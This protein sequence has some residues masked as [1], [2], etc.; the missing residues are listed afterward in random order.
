M[1]TL[2]LREVSSKVGRR[3]ETYRRG[4]GISYEDLGIAPVFGR[5]GETV[6]FLSVYLDESYSKDSPNLIVGGFVSGIDRWA[7]F[8]SRWKVEVQEQFKVP[9]LHMK[10]LMSEKSSLYRHLHPN[11]WVGLLRTA[12]TIIKEQADFAVAYSIN[13]KEYEKITTQDERSVYG[14]AY[15]L[16]VMGCLQTIE[17]Q[18][19]EKARTT[20]LNIYLENGHRSMDQAI[21]ILQER[22]R[23]QRD[24]HLPEIPPETI[25]LRDLERK[26]EG[27][28]VQLGTIA[29]G[30]KSQMMPLQAADLLA[31]SLLRSSDSLF[32]PLLFALVMDIDM[33]ISLLGCHMAAEG[34]RVSLDK[35]LK[36][37]E[38][39]TEERNK[40]ARVVGLVGGKTRQKGPGFYV[41]LKNVDEEDWERLVE[42][43]KTGTVFIRKRTTGDK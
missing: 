15:T 39:A 19:G 32:E 20:T 1:K 10:D 6:A 27:P 13:P 38:E 34:I 14:T 42:A 25:I 3:G 12:V 22:W 18:L 8:A 29:S 17:R 24:L 33:E 4:G 30:T 11:G 2:Q 37:L 36:E 41:S 21:E 23:A 43:V 5:G 31:Y 26:R 40:I 16:A 28:E 9:Y 7:E 35:H